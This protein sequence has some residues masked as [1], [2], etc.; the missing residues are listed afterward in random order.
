MDSIHLFPKRSSCYSELDL[1]SLVVYKNQY[2]FHTKRVS[3]GP[4]GVIEDLLIKSI[5]LPSLDLGFCVPR[6]MDSSTQN[7]YLGV[8]NVVVRSPAGR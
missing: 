1:R 2:V 4:P 3:R 7:S 8:I 5:Q 6:V